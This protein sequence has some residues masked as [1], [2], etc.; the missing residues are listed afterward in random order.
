MGSQRGVHDWATN[1][2]SC[3]ILVSWPGLEPGPGQWKCQ[4]LTTGPPGAS[5][6]NL[7]MMPALWL[8]AWLLYQAIIT[9]YRKYNK[10]SNHVLNVCPLLDDHSLQGLLLIFLVLLRK[11]RLRDNKCLLLD[12][13]ACSVSHSCP[14]LCDPMDYSPPGSSVHGILQVRVLGWSAMPS[15]RGSAWPR[16]PAQSPVFPTLIG[17]FLTHWATWEVHFPLWLLSKWNMRQ[18]DSRADVF[19]LTLKGYFLKNHGYNMW[20]VISWIVYQV[21]FIH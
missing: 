2:H 10:K 8:L 14:T 20:K 16:D 13:C 17:M 6:K 4:V 5:Q 7:T 21:D 1:T 9:F 19:Y 12:M 15:S 11:P 3:R 18:L